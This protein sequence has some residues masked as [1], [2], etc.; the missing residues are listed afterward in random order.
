MELA[1]RKDPE[2]LR[3]DQSGALLRQIMETAAVGMVLVGVDRRLLFVNAAFC[4]MF[5]YQRDVALG[6]EVDALLSS[7]DPAVG[8]QVGRL[9][10]GESD[11]HRGEFRFRHRD[12]SAIWML[13]S[14]SVLRSDRTGR[15]LYVIL[16][17]INIERQKRAE[18]ALTYS[19]SRWSSA[20][21]AA[22]QGV[23][24][25]DVRTDG[26]YYSPMW[27]KMRGIPPDEYV[28]PAMESWLARV[29]PEDRDRIRAVVKKQD[30]GED[31]YDTLEYRERHRDGHYIWILS[32]GRPVE[33]DSAGRPIRTIGTDT[34]ITRLK[35]A[36][37]SLAEE[38][39]RL[40]VTLQSIGDGVIS[41][42]AQSCITFMNPLA[43]QMTGWKSANA[44]GRNVDEVFAIESE[45]PGEG[46][47]D[48]VLE[49]LSRGQPF[50]LEA[51]VVLISRKGERRDVRSSAAPVRTPD[52][53]VIGA[54][55]V[56]QDVTHS[57]ALQK[58]LAHSA[59]HDPLTG[60]P[61]RSALERA[62]AAAVDTAGEGQRMHALCFIDLDRFKPVNDNA[63]HA[64]GDALLRLVGETIRHS[65]RSNDVAARIG[66]DE[67]ALL[68]IDCPMESAMVVA[69][70]VVAA[71][72][73]LRFAWSG[74][75]YRIG[76]SIGV[77]PITGA[78]PQ[79]GFIGEADAACYAAKAAGRGRAIAYPELGGTKGTSSP[80]A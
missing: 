29:H 73:G 67:F 46:V 40:R 52:G 68:L 19:E 36:E 76:A 49:C 63:G 62:L 5:G 25:H 27:R 54:V 77:T 61:N 66:G 70:K 12:G 44:I 7:D 41:T 6:L 80:A 39:E 65:C 53:R 71:I 60:L 64:A 16:Q 18:A 42:D 3:F 21:D 33:W 32:R 13:V 23:W 26:M 9:L 4:E 59:N 11:Q 75:T 57:R 10:R 47:K 15:P 55:L 58:R 51:D 20:L 1:S 37:A 45:T 34:D 50:Y 48:P 31:G 38:K 2:V 30:H 69:Q 17:L 72:A 79:L 56:F 8:L 74:V 43:E 24:D 22:G 78:E 28:D 35:I 14:A